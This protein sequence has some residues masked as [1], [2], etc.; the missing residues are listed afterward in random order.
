MTL[1]NI[2]QL[3]KYYDEFDHCTK[4]KSKCIGIPLNSKKSAQLMIESLIDKDQEI[5]N[6]YNIKLKN[7]Y[8]IHKINI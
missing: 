5:Q 7:Q 6:E 8:Y 2:I 1:Y 4:T 3:S